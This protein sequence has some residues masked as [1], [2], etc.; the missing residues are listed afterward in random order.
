MIFEYLLIIIKK[1]K[2]KKILKNCIHIKVKTLIFVNWTGDQIALR[3]Y[4]YTQINLT[5]STNNYFN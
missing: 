4:R 5:L 1:K 3:I 2:V